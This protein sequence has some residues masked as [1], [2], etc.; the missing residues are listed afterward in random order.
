VEVKLKKPWKNHPAGTVI[1]S[2]SDG[3]M[4][5]L[6]KLGVLDTGRKKPSKKPPVVSMEEKTKSVISPV[7]KMISEAPKEKK[8]EGEAKSPSSSKE[9]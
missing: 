6:R 1:E 3:V 8:E 4:S 2:V 9:K 7:N 5:D